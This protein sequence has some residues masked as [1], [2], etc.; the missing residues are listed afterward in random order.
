MGK[1]GLTN[2]YLVLR[3]RDVLFACL[4]HKFIGVGRLWMKIDYS[5]IIDYRSL[6]FTYR[7]ISILDVHISS[8]RL[9]HSFI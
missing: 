4:V 5:L 7:C 6:Y 9:V 2:G 3:R 1:R 8:Y